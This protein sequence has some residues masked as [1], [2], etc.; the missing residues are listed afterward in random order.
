MRVKRG[1]TVQKEE[2]VSHVKFCRGTENVRNK[3]NNTN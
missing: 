1:E 2:M 3:N